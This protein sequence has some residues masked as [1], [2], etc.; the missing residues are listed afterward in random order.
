MD[1]VQAYPRSRR[2][3]NLACGSQK[4]CGEISLASAQDFQ[5]QPLVAVQTSAQ[6]QVE[7]VNV[8]V[9]WFVI[10]LGLYYEE[11]QSI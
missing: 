4:T 9:L 10:G 7:E 11:L 5:V 3:S 1:T 8:K 6:Q 2:N